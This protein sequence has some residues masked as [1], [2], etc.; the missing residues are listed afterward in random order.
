[1]L[2]M[3]N[4]DHIAGEALPFIIERLMAQGA[5]NVHV[6]Q[7]MT[8]K[9]RWEFLF[10]IDLPEEKIDPVSRF[11]VTQLGTLGLRAF[12]TR[13]IKFLYAETQ[14]LLSV[15]DAAT[16]QDCFCEVIRVKLIR[17]REDEVAAAK[18]EY[19]DLRAALSQLADIGL[20]VPFA[21]LKE[22]IE[23]AAME[24]TCK[25]YKNLRIEPRVKD[26]AE[27]GVTWP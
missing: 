5:G 1:M 10:F 19:E 12:D 18:T 21:T 6:V 22:L 7:A 16:S 26:E 3:A 11:L 24:G 4:V 17:N 15:R 27:A 14:V 13:H 8:K 25:T 20:D 9:G 2:I 23:R